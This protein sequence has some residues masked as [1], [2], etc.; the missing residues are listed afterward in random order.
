MRLFERGQIGNLSIKN[1]IYMLP[2]RPVL[3]DTD[4]SLSQRAIDFYTARAKGGAGIISTSLWMVD[5]ELEAKMENGRCVYP[6]AD[7]DHLHRSNQP[8]G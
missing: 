5:R 6:M 7:G 3:L 1:R 4:G 2:M 8:T